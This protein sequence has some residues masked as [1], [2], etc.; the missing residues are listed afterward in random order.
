MDKAIAAEVRRRAG[1]YCEYCKFPQV[2]FRPH[3]QID[4]IIARQHGGM[5]LPDNLALAC[6]RCN[7]HKG[8]NIAGLDPRTGQ[9]TSLFH[10]RRDA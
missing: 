5:T 9:L 8:P 2:A 3:F 10:S 6:A 7:L 4:H 1:D